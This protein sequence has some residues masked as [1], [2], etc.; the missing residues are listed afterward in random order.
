MHSRLQTLA[1]SAKEEFFKEIHVSSHNY[2]ALSLMLRRK[3]STNKSSGDTNWIKVITVKKCS[4]DVFSSLVSWSPNLRRIN[5]T[6]VPA[7]DQLC[8]PSFVQAL[9]QSNRIEDITIPA[10][11]DDVIDYDTSDNEV[12][13][14]DPTDDNIAADKERSDNEGN[15]GGSIGDRRS[16]TGSIGDVSM[17]DEDS[18]DEGR[19]GE[20]SDDELTF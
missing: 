16:D 8:V 10:T 11:K 2:D 19:G 3:E 5:F 4:A 18:D 1:P 13:D 7:F 9:S 14:N 20:D 6:S 15:E 17:D 12:S